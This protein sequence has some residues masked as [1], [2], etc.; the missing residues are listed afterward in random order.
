VSKNRNKF[1]PISPRKVEEWRRLDLEALQ[2]L[3]VSDARRAWILER[4]PPNEMGRPG[5]LVVSDRSERQTENKAI[6]DKDCPEN[7]QEPLEDDGEDSIAV[8]VT[9]D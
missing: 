5:I 1:Q 7:G 9:A 4:Y 2:S 3:I 8:A 6:V